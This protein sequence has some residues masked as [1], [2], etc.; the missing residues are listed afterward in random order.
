MK[1]KQTSILIVF[2][3]SFISSLAI[4]QPARQLVEIII[5][6]M[7][8][9]WVYKINERCDFEVKVLINGQ[10]LTNVQAS[11]EIS[12]EQMLTEKKG[13]IQLNGERKIIEG[14][15]LK[16][17]GFVKCAVMVEYKGKKYQN[18]G[19]AGV[20][21]DKIKPV[22]TMPADFDAFWEKAKADLANV[23]LEP[24]LT[25][26]PEQCTTNINVYHISF[27]NIAIA[28]W[29]GHSRMYGML[30]VPK[31]PGK[32]PAILDVPGAGVRPYFRDDRANRG[33]IV[34]KMGIH[35]IPVNQ[36]QE[37]YDQLNRSSLAN[38][39]TY[40]IENRDKYYYKRVFLGCVKAIDFIY[41]LPEFDGQNL[42][43]SGGSQGG[44]L[45]I[46]VAGLDQRI[47]YLF[48]VYPAMCDMNAYLQGQA[49]GWPHMYKGQKPADCATWLQVTP[50]YDVVNFAKKLKIPGWYA[51]GFNDNV[52]PPT[53]MYAAYNS[54]TAPKDLVLFKEIGHWTFP[55]LGQQG[56]DW[57]IGNLKNGK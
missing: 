48:A 2:I 27:Q 55:E 4:A 28:G 38:Y 33:V 36:S 22:V 39:P 35:G 19:Q 20:E 10:F 52:C 50:Y 26:V 31:K 18:W 25:L 57:L 51:W 5:T 53:S 29:L 15:A 11:Y 34:L 21:P 14:I 24:N 3:I 56:N 43:I 54:I 41:S 45:S 44:A 16:Q 40:N 37:I 6:P 42:G 32:Y 46:I 12:P 8:E 9:S 13:E 7:K 23:P 30:S 47:K 1:N 49:G 17:P